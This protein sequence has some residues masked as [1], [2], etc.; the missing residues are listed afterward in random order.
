MKKNRSMA[1]AAAVMM[2][3]TFSSCR[4]T[5]PTAPAQP[6]TQTEAVQTTK[7]VTEEITLEE[8]ARVLLM[9]NKKR[10]YKSSRK[11]KDG[12]ECYPGDGC[13]FPEK[14]KKK[15]PRREQ[16]LSCLHFFRP[17]CGISLIPVTGIDAVHIVLYVFALNRYR[18]KNQP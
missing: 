10:G 6:P 5:E 8:F 9:I 11:V 2:L 14:G 18:T 13:H 4:K 17:E 1:L 15:T 3:M 12:E 7:A 16:I